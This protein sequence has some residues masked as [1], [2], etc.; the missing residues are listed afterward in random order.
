MAGF[1]SKRTTCPQSFF[2]FLFRRSCY[3]SIYETSVPIAFELP[4]HLQ[5]VKRVVKKVSDISAAVTGPAD[6]P[7]TNYVQHY[8]RVGLRIL[9]FYLELEY[10]SPY[11]TSLFRFYDRWWYIFTLS[12]PPDC[13]S[14]MPLSTVM[15]LRG[16]IY[17]TLHL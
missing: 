8:N 16:I 17:T 3:L 14:L 6:M 9:Q 1:R 4:S 2:P 12:R 7:A 10:L 5:A 11:F 15:V 13:S